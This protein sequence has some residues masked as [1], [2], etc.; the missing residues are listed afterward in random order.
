MKKSY[1]FLMTIM[2]FFFSVSNA[3]AKID[4]NNII[5]IGTG[6]VTGIYYPAGAAI[7]KLIN[8]SQ[9]NNYIRCSVESTAGSSYNIKDLEEHNLDLAIIQSDSQY[10][11]YNGSDFYKTP[12]KNL[13]SLFSLHN[14]TLTVI[15]KASSN[16]NKF[17][18]IE[19]KKI[20]I[21]NLGSGSRALIESLF[22]LYGWNHKN[23]ASITELKPSEQPEALC[24]DKI[25][26]MIYNV[27]HPNGAV[28]E[29]VSTCDTRLI[30]IEGDKIEKLL[31][32]HPYYNQAIIKGGIYAGNPKAIKTF[33][34]KATV[35]TLDSLDDEIAYYI[36]KV[37]FE[38]IDS[39]K[40][41][42]PV[43]NNLD[44]NDMAK[45]GIMA[46]LHPGAK[47]YFIEKNIL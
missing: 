14:D 37:I 5:H 32:S 36:V 47:R 3:F 39:F 43:F 40:K 41:L 19:G 4:L 13:R 12:N 33:G 46:P 17:E 38:N 44:I 22:K 18:D 29:A 25:D 11:A 45:K 10:F 16:I 35:T 26:V 20:N 24:S 31:A 9:D 23:F 21:G 27:G 7:C 8:I 28:Q 15:V 42:H 34:A 6:N 2:S 1:I 30:S